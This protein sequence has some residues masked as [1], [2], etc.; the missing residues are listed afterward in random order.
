MPIYYLMGAN[1]INDDDEEHFFECIIQFKDQNQFD[2]VGDHM[3]DTCHDCLV[4]CVPPGWQIDEMPE[5]I[6]KVTEEVA[7]EKGFQAYYPDGERPN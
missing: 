1:F 7:K 6:R 3:F 2:M 5:P 4:D